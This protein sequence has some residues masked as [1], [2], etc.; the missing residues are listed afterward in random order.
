MWA[1]KCHYY[2]PD[3]HYYNFP[4]AFGLLFGKGIYARYLKEG[5]AFRET[6]D[7]LLRQTALD[8]AAEVAAI[9]GIDLADPAFW[10]SSLA[11]LEQ[12]VDQLAACL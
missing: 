12:S 1:C 6:Y 11:L 5:P 2:S 3:L 9:V 10:H 4:Y 8:D 7:Q